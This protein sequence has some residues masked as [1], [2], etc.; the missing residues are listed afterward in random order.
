MTLPE[1]IDS[2]SILD[3]ISQYAEFEEKGGEYWCLSPLNEEMTPSFSV[4]TEM[5]RFFDFSSG[6]GGNILSFIKYYHRC[7]DRQ[8]INI[9]KEYAGEKGGLAPSQ[10]LEA[11]LVAKQFTHKKKQPK[12]SK[13]IILPDNY[14]ERYS[15]PEDKL[16]IWQSEGISDESLARFQVGY[17][18]FSER[19]VYPIRNMEGKI[20]NV[21]GRTIDP[22]WK[23]KKLRKYTYF[24][25]LG[26]LDTI[27]GFAENRAAIMEKKEIILFEGAKSV[28]LADTYGFKNAGALLTSHLNPFQLKILTMLGCR[29]VF[30][31]DKGVNI[32]EDENISKLRR[33]VRVE[34]IWDKD[35]MLEDKMSPVDAGVE[36]WKKLYEGRL[37]YR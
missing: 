27:Y 1:L 34:Y 8:A 4:N 15:R 7:G 28:M 24:Q 16:A 31:L 19:L 5:N 25:P 37:Y 9:L 29:V 36:V 17:D 2:V 26:I 22:A 12:T 3:Y 10:K 21:S 20:I 23:E 35:G 33:F 11:T 18:E 14:M 30:A 32:R 6:K 13:S